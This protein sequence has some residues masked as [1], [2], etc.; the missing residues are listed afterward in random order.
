MA[1]LERRYY[2]FFGRVQGVG[3][4]YRAQYAAQRLGLTGWVANQWDGSVELEAQGEPAQLDQL[5]PTILS[6]SRWISIEDWQMKR[7][8][9]KPEER[10]FRV[11]GGY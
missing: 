1:E 10:S 4:R 8:P 3:F 9:P 6:G 2:H 5:V 11:T 7:I